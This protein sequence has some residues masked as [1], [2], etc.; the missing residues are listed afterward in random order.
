[1]RKTLRWLRDEPMVY[2]LLLGAAIFGVYQRLHGSGE[3][4]PG[5]I[6]VTQGRIESLARGFSLTWRRAPNASELDEL[7]QS[8][9]REEI[10]VREAIALGLD[11]DDTI[12]RR[13]LQ[14]KLEFVSEDLISR[15]EPTE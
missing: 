6:V 8:Y 14:Q 5:E 9:V 4:P 2:F 13:R 3:R 11:R 1:M 7:V 10:Y 15:A 12:I